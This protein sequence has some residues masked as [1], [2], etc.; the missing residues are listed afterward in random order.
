VPLDLTLPLTL[1]TT[2][3]I[4]LLSKLDAGQELSYTVHGAFHLDKAILNKIAL[5][6]NIT[7]TAL[8]E[9]GFEDFFKQ[10]SHCK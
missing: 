5:P 1:K 8:V 3:A 10:E 6:I 2:D 4:Q 7:G 9:T